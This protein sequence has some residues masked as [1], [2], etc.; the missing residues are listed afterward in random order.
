MGKSIGVLIP[1][2][3]PAF[4]ALGMHIVFPFLM[5]VAFITLVELPIS[6]LF[7]AFSDGLRFFV[8]HIDYLPANEYKT[9]EQRNDKC[10]T[11]DQKKIAEP[12]CRD[13]FSR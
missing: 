4:S 9:Q 5:R 8:I 3:Y 13:D 2:I 11:E 1:N 12:S 10:N 7:S 6:S